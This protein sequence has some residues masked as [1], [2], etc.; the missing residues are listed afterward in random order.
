MTHEVVSSEQWLERR[1]ELLAKDDILDRLRKRPRRWENRD[2]K[3]LPNF[4]HFPGPGI[5]NP[6]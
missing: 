3:D 1:R 2:I 5:I 4:D 6:S